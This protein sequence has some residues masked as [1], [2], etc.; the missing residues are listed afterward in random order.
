[1][2]HVN[3]LF[4]DKLNEQ[5]KEEE[6]DPLIDIGTCDLHTNHGILKAEIKLS[7]W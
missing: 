6:L 3:L 2:G 5:R 1:M 4:L 7:G